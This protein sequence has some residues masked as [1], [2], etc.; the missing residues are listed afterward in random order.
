MSTHSPEP[1]YPIIST[2]PKCGSLPDDPGRIIDAHANFIA[3]FP[4]EADT[5]RAAACVNACAGIEDPE[6]ILNLVR[7]TLKKAAGQSPEAYQ[8]C[9]L[10]AELSTVYGLLAGTIRKKQP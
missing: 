8:D 4:T 1:W 9:E 2:R 7:D 3:E 6:T 10:W 5:L